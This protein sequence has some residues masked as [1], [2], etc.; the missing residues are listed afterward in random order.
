MKTCR[1][2][3][4]LIP[5]FVQIILIDI[6]LGGDN[7]IVIA[8]AC[9]NLP[10]HLRTRGI[11]WGTFGAGLLGYLAGEMIFS[12]AAVAPWVQAHWPR[13]YVVIPGLGAHLGIPGMVGAAIVVV[14]GYVLTGMRTPVKS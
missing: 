4:R 1:P 7:A 3:N 6:L 10:L 11:L 12:D 14:T 2:A 5:V 9:R 13:P 8:L